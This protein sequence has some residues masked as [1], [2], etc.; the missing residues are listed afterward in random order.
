MEGIVRRAL[1]G[2]MWIAASGALIAHAEEGADWARW[3]AEAARVTIV[4]DDWGIAHV[5]GKTDADAVFGMIYAQCEDDFNR[6]EM[7]YL[8]AL[9][10]RAEAEGEPAI[11]QDLR[12]RLFI[13][14]EELKRDYVASPEWLKKLM[15]AWADGINYYLARHPETRPKVLTT[16]EPWMALSFTEGSIGGDI[17]RIDLKLL[18]AFYDAPGAHETGTSAVGWEARPHAAQ[19]WPAAAQPWI[20]DTPASAS[21]GI[22][23]APGNT[24][25]HRALLLINPHT[26]FFFRSELQMSSDEGL[27][28]FGAVTWGQFF[29][30]QGFN[31]RA[32]WM[33]TS[34]GVDAVDEY[35]ETLAHDS[36]KLAYRYGGEIRQFTSRQITLQFKSPEGMKSRTFT[37]MYTLHGPVIGKGGDKFVT[38]QLMNTPVT[39]LEQSYL[40]TKAHNYAEYEKT[41]E[42]RANS[43]NNTVFADADGD[44][45]YWQGNFIPKRDPRF[46]YT[47]P[48]DGSD[49]STNWQGLLAVS[50]TPHLL[51]PRSGFLFNVNDS[52]W[53]G[54]G[55]DSLRKSDYPAYVEEG[56]ES[57]RGIHA[58]Q[59][60]A[61]EGKPRRD[62]TLESLMHEAYDSYM[63]WFA[64]TVPVLVKAYDALPADAALRT[65]LAGQ[66]K[67][68]RTWDDRWG[69]DSVQTALAIFW[70]NEL[71]KKNRQLAREASVPSEEWVATR[72][73]ADELLAALTTA[74]DQLANDFGTWRTPWGEVN[75]FQRL[76]DELAPKFTDAGAS[77][78]I[79]F[80][81]SMWGS[82]AAY[83]G[84]AYP[85]TKRWYGNYG[86]TF[87]AV[88]EFGDKVRAR[89]VTAGGESGDPKSPHFNDQVQS[90]AEGNLREIYFY[91]EQLKEH[92]QRTYHPG[93]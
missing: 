62:F 79:G 43:S 11:W 9:G 13:D 22:A 40:R 49:P 21:N 64:R 91:P 23:I 81:P 73:G 12:Q 59:L 52:P 17:G 46:D 42:L 16:F 5:H 47:R 25:D 2:L 50:E 34:S 67:M 37:A 70:G 14:P 24:R 80:V 29:V 57:A 75:R 15:D 66:V 76:T 10:R 55:P 19:P 6:V 86:N 83:V 93:E 71:L 56:I 30:Y 69:V 45:A 63:P 74:S 38:I 60:L 61:P 44:I 41:M 88:V 51:N 77:T 68:L 33:H 35:L 48:V 28:A 53:N 3:K 85:G 54:A 1:L 58:M 92:T 84:R 31:D 90:Y 20:E 4:R 65:R 39:A 72:V 8:T 7:N 32:G 27:N 26:W 87:V 36:G 89:G 82:F 78:P 18:Q